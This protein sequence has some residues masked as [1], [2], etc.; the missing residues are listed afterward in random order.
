MTLRLATAADLPRIVEIYNSTI[1]SRRATA[2]LEPVTVDERRPWFEA[3]DPASRPLYVHEREG[4]VVAW[5]SFESFYGRPAY[6]HTAEISVYVDGEY[7]ARG[8]G[9]TLLGEAL[10][11][12]PA[13]G[14]RTLVGYVFAHNEPSL[15][16][17]RNQGFSEWGR[18]PEI[19]EM[20]GEEYSLCILG[21]RLETVSSQA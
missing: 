5:V 6:R 15:R 20:D 16:L 10:A 7:R 14:I 13:L 12:A 3:H 9:R 21:K 4:E 18:L 17:L 11:K 8:L 1:A 2:D 19:A